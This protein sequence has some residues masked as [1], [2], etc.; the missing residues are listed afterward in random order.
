M[1]PNWRPIK[2]ERPAVV[3]GHA[4]YPTCALKNRS[5]AGPRSARNSNCGFSPS[6]F[7]A[8]WQKSGC[9]ESMWPG[10]ARLPGYSQS[11]YR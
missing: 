5:R 6:M 2:R 7:R 8:R 10:H 9:Q 1:M 4:G 3:A 11:G